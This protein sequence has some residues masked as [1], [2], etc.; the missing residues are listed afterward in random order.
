MIVRQL[1]M[2]IMLIFSKIIM[3][4]MAGR[5]PK[6][7]EGFLGLRLVPTGSQGL[8]FRSNSQSMN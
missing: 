5:V 6:R 3:C 1:G 8:M 2:E 7:P 4:I